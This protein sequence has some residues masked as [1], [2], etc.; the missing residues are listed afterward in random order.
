ME[1]TTIRLD[2]VQSVALAIV[3]YYIGTWIK[4]QSP[5]LQKFSIP[6]P[7]IGGLPFAFI[8]SCLKIFGI[9]DF[10]FDDT[11]QKVALLCF[12]TTIGMMASLKLVK[13]GGILLVG[14]WLSS[15]VLGILQNAVGMG[16]CSLMGIDKFYG[17]LSGAVALMGGLGT[18]AAFGPFFEQN[19]G[20]TGATTVAITAATFG[21]AVALILGGPF[22]ESVLEAEG[23]GMGEIL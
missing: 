4:N 9:A 5:L 16:V 6:A 1:I 14:F 22:G 7:V 20:L 15:T 3:S 18:S 13:K 2:M 23:G 10:T 21:M 11:L 19:Y 12:F 8:F 17:I